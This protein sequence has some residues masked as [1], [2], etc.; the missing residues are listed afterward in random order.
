MRE[1]KKEDNTEKIRLRDD[2]ITKLE[3]KKTFKCQ[4]ACINSLDFSADDKLLVAGSNDETIILYDLIAG[5]QSQA[6]LNL[7]NGCS[8]IKFAENSCSTVLCSSTI[9]MERIL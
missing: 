4:N 6:L 3:I 2:L 1:E 9:S 7:E 5:K 8:H